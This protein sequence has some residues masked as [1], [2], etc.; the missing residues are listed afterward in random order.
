MRLRFLST[1]AAMALW[2]ATS[3]AAFVGTVTNASVGGMIASQGPVW[4]PPASISLSWN[5]FETGTPGLWHYEYTLVT[6]S[7]GEM[8]HFI[9]EMSANVTSNTQI[10]GLTGVG[11]DDGIGDYGP[12]G[13]NPGIPG[14]IHGFKFGAANGTTTT[15][16]FD[17]ERAPMFGDFYTKDGNPNAAWNTGFGGPRLTFDP[18][19]Y[20]AGT[21]IYSQILVPDSSPFVTSA[22]APPSIVLLASAGVFGLGRL[23]RRRTVL[24]A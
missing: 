10:Q 19:N 11:V 14:A 3:S 21:N 6:P 24:V 22:P 4:A 5:I 23:I 16:S 8:S 9:L 12:S 15:W 13:S 18:N 17:I 20:S 7:G 2:A 1:L